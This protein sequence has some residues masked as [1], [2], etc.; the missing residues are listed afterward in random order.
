MPASNCLILEGKKRNV[1]W[2]CHFWRAGLQKN[3]EFAL[4][5]KSEELFLELA[6]KLNARG[7]GRRCPFC[8]TSLPSLCKRG[9]TNGKLEFACAQQRLI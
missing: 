7:R 5:K 6:V 4:L 9:Q 1:K 8:E 3:V 2:S